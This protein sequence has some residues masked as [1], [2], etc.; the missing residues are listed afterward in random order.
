MYHAVITWL[1]SPAIYLL[2]TPASWAEILGFVTG[3]GCV[4]LTW[5]QHIWNFPIGIANSALLLMLFVDARLFADA[6]LQ[7]LFICLGLRGWWEWLHGI[8]GEGPLQVR[9]A[10][11]NE[12]LMAIAIAVGLISVMWP[13]LSYV[14]GGAPFM[15]AAVTALSLV[16]QGLLN[17]KRMESWL[18]W[19]VVDLISIPLYASKQL[20]LVAA[21][22]VIFLGMATKGFFTWR[23]VCA[24]TSQRLDI[25]VASGRA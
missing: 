25:E 11:R 5:R 12:C 21:L 15:D 23:Q 9:W 2:G 7:I 18:F 19:I 24:S 6:T 1:N 3:I 10:G 8:R 17:R 16:A 20:Y 4:W 14:K 13:I 22:Y